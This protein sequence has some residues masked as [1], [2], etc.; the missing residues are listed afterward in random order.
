VSPK[1]RM[2]CHMRQTLR[3]NGLRVFSSLVVA[4]DFGLSH[5][6]RTP[7]GRRRALRRR[8]RSARALDGG[9]PIWEG[10]ESHSGPP[11][12][13]GG[14]LAHVVGE[15]RVAS[16]AWSARLSQ[17]REWA[18]RPIAAGMGAMRAYQQGAS[19]TVELG[20]P[21][22]LSAESW[23]FC[24]LASSDDGTSPSS[25]VLRTSRCRTSSSATATIR[26]S[27]G[28]LGRIEAIRARCAS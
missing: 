1:R 16:A 7:F 19:R 14:R 9:D 5:A 22:T 24:R 23:R 27:P 18:T 4:A 28:T 12:P 3:S 2:I 6:C 13:A 17:L 11:A 26:S 25:N 21:P 8:P 10:P 15:Y 20:E